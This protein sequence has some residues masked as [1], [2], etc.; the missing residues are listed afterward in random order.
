VIVTHL[1]TFDCGGGAAR[2]TLRIHKSL[3]NIGVD[4]RVRVMKKTI[5]EPSV[6]SGGYFE[7]LMSPFKRRM[8]RALVS[9]LKTENPIYHSLGIGPCW[10]DEEINKGVSDIV[11]LHWVGSDFLSIEG[12]GRIEKPIV[13]T[14]HD[15]WAFC[16]AEHHP[17]NELDDRYEQGYE[18]SNRPSREK[19]IDWNRFVYARK[20][21][22]WRKNFTFV[23]PST[24]MCNKL[25]KSKLFK[26]QQCYK[27]PI[28]VDASVFR[29]LDR[30]AC[31]KSIG[32]VGFSKVIMFAAA[33]TV[34]DPNKG[35][36][37]LLRA[38]HHISR[39]DK[40]VLLLIVGPIP[41]D[42]CLDA[43]G[44]QTKCMGLVRDDEL[45]SRIYGACDVVVVPSKV[46]NF[47]L[48]AVEA[49]TSSRVAIG[50]NVA[51]LPDVIDDGING[52]LADPFDAKSL[53]N[54]I[55]LVIDNCELAESLGKAGRLKSLMMWQPNT[56]AAQYM[57]LYKGV[58]VS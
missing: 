11:N 47:P 26:G 46:E 51:G 5:Y 29:P 23:A 41:S 36:D 8:G 22:Y 4:S 48:M 18:K 24:W 9:L 3:Q 31:Q 49:L 50:F 10:I 15:S 37:L 58:S 44:Y 17:L 12:I 52:F 1:S 43:L 53:A 40:S 42:F 45:M 19:G 30:K 21:R 55:N 33:S 14:L 20:M 38:L 35:L 56:I 27:I 28:P 16:G 32:I 6:F 25:N 57:S 13:W 34:S 7:N 39:C 54:K 2:A